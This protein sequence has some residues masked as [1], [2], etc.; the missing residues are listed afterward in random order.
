MVYINKRKIRYG[1]CYYC[2]CTACTRFE[3]PFSH[4]L[5]RECYA[6]HE[7]GENRPRLD[8]DYFCHYMKKRHFKFKREPVPI[9]EH[10]GTYFLYAKNNVYIGTYEELVK[11]SKRIGGTPCKLNIFDENFNLK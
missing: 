7:R 8:C 1:A 4:K 2:I 3:C 5:Y 10:S 6:C 9:P 11:V